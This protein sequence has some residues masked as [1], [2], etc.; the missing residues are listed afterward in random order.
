MA[1]Y[2]EAKK[3]LFRYVL[4]NKKEIKYASFPADDKV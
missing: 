3:K 2:A 4:D 1:D